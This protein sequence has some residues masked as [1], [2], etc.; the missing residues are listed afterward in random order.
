M[1]A[2]GETVQVGAAAK[3]TLHWIRHNCYGSGCVS[4]PPQQRTA[5]SPLSNSAVFRGHSLF[6][7]HL[8]N[9]RPPIAA[10]AHCAAAFAIADLGAGN[11][12]MHTGKVEKQLGTKRESV[13]DMQPIRAQMKMMMLEP[14][15][16]SNAL[17]N[18]KIC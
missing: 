12:R 1:T 15:V 2:G 8:P 7:H 3:G 13:M 18:K 11:W 5:P 16:Q 14:R 17:G 4:P 9:P 6:G 10:A